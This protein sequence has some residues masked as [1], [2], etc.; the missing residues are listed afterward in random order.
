MGYGGTSLGKRSLLIRTMMQL[1]SGWSGSL[2]LSRY[3]D[4]MR[5]PVL[6][7]NPLTDSLELDVIEWG[8][9]GGQVQKS[10]H[11]IEDCTI[12][13]HD[14]AVT[15]SYY[16]FVLNQVPHLPTTLLC[17]RYAM[18]GTDMGYLLPVRTYISSVPDGTQGSC[19][20]LARY[21]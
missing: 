2:P 17:I 8:E 1:P 20:V 4:P 18:S 19:G 13:P 5:S 10:S 14:F 16:V 11:V 9:E 15:S 12:A 6:N 21:R 7:T 3:A